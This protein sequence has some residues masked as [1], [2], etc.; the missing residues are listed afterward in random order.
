[1]NKN[2]IRLLDEIK[3]HGGNAHHRC[4]CGA[5]SYPASWL[6]KTREKAEKDGL[7]ERCV[8]CTKDTRLWLKVINSEPATNNEDK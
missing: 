1:M 2:T 7:L 5:I 3:A 4:I 6:T 8:D